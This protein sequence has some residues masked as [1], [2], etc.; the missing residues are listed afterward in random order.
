MKKK[1]DKIISAPVLSLNAKIELFAKFLRNATLHTSSEYKNLSPTASDTNL[2]KT[3]KQV[4]A[5][6]LPKNSSVAKK[7][8]T[9]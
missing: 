2:K 5:K 3:V 9:A 8:K 7:K 1:N 4:A 6:K